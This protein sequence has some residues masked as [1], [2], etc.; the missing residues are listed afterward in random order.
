LGAGETIGKRGVGGLTA[1]QDDI[2]RAY[3]DAISRII[4]I[5]PDVCLHS[6]DL[7]HQVRPSNRI[8]AVASAGLNRLASEAGI[9]TIII[10]GNH[11]APRL[12]QSWAALEVFRTI[13]NLRIAAS[14]GVHTYT[15]GDTTFHAVPHSTGETSIREF[16]ESCQPSRST[17]H[18]VLITHGVVAGMPEFAM[19]ELGE[20]E[21]P[22]D[23]LNRFDYVAL[24]HY[25]NFARVAERAYY[26]GSTERLSQS[27]RDFAKGFV[28]IVLDPFDIRFHEVP[29]R[30]M[31]TVRLP[32]MSGKRGDEIG[33]MIAAQAVRAGA[34]DNIVRLIVPGISR[35]SLKTLPSDL[36][37][38][39]KK[40]SFALDIRFES[41]SAESL[42]SPTT[43]H[44]GI[45][46]LDEA[47]V[48]FL[49]RSELSHEDKARLRASAL[50][51]L[52]A[53]DD[54]S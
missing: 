54:E 41:S 46:R 21:F 1:R 47:F 39:L 33:E 6:G 34:S 40:S 43:L 35:E 30:G 26:A 28:E 18:N 27:E 19:A 5:R 23:T 17:H 7:F 8:L 29:S 9:P 52:R 2:I 14:D 31:A 24:G 12:A 10:T 25:H 48:A 38:E 42:P 37:A 15:I 11:D 50:Q 20:Q 53:I 45:G 3:D 22:I 51:Y 49:D 4:A 16:V 32:D 44:E 13:D 36:I